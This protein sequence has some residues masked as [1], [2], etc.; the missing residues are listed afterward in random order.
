MSIA[1]KNEII[2]KEQIGEGNWNERIAFKRDYSTASCTVSSINSFVYGGFSSRFWLMRKHINSMPSSEL[3]ELPFHCW[4]CITI[5]T[6][7]RDIDLVIRN[8]KD[9]KYLLEFLIISLKTLDGNRDSAKR[10]LM[11]S[12]KFKHNPNHGCNFF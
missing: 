10:Y 2:V 8:E 9:M 1:E 5:K 6:D 7:S 12:N 4:E 3:N 11:K